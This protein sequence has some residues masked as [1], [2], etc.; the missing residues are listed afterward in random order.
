LERFRAIYDPRRSRRR[1]SAIVGALLVV[2]A[3]IGFVLWPPSAEKLL[4]QAQE[5]ANDGE[6]EKARE[7]ISRLVED[8]PDSPEA[9]QAILMQRRLFAPQRTSPKLA[10]AAQELK[11]TL[12]ARM[13]GFL[14]ALQQLP[15]PTAQS[16]VG[17]VVDLL[18]VSAAKPLR[19]G[20]LKP[21]TA[22]LRTAVQEL[23]TEAMA[24]VDVLAQTG[25]AHERLGQDPDG[26][27][28]FLKE[29]EGARDTEWLDE[30][31]STA[32][33]MH[34][35]GR[36]HRDE[37]FRATTTELIRAVDALDK[38]AQYHDRSMPAVRLAFASL[39]VE[40]ADR[41]CR[42]EAPALMVAGQID[43][44]DAIYAHLETLLQE[45][46]TDPIYAPLIERVS[47]RQLQR[48]ISDRRDQ[49][50][51]IRQRM[52]QAQAAETAGDLEEAIRLYADMVSTYWLIRFENVFTL[53]LKVESVPAGARVTHGGEVLGRTPVIV[54]YPWGSTGKIKLEAPG[55]EA[56]EHD[57]TARGGTPAHQV[58]LALAPASLWT[59]PVSTKVRV[60]PLAVGEH[61]LVME[62]RGQITMYD[63]A[64]GDLRWAKDHGSL[65]GVRG[66]PSLSRGMLYVPHVDGHL[67]FISA[68]DGTKLGELTLP[69]LKGD[70]A[71]IGGRTA[72][73]TSDGRCILL[74]GRSEI[75]R[76]QLSATPSAGV[77]AAHGAFWI[78][79][80][81]GSVVRIDASTQVRRE[82]RVTN[83]RAAIAGIGADPR[84]VCVNTAHGSVVALD[85]G[86]GER[87]R[88]DKIGDLV[89]APAYASDRVGVAARDGVVTLYEAGTGR[90][91]RRYEGVGRPRGGLLGVGSSLLLVRADG[92]LWTVDAT[93]GTLLVNMSTP[94]TALF[95][96][97]LLPGNRVALPYGKGR[98]GVIPGP[99]K[100]A[101]AK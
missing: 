3:S 20:I 73:V 77:V 59:S 5:A 83:N 39:Q 15:A 38:A 37:N 101:P 23:L 98:L 47:R 93:S 96:P 79:L 12:E 92:S 16:A 62:R 86:G 34:R 71:S 22:A 25:D 95:P 19:T 100:P 46:A 10:K 67:L 56:R 17:E 45:Y 27:R 26:M 55:Y 43:R 97:A 94:A 50:K 78:G 11:Q 53:P 70:A 21:Q 51:D 61:V 14:E 40:E 72:V 66:R 7:L 54:R 87:W 36:L 32:K 60:R 6:T 80:I 2:L 4:M 68:D 75:A 69:R 58:M 84:G 28:A 42:E 52:K 8:F 85:A 82:M 35:L 81:D 64:T 29:A 99:R 44:A 49:I 91:V 88:H 33:L 74:E 31:R 30:T 18:G 13:P 90:T 24:R 9:E 65:E 57:L 48:L 89:G 41:R 63:G 76:I 1:K